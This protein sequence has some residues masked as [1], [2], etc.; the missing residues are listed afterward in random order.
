MFNGISG[1]MT[2]VW[3]IG[4]PC[5][6]SRMGMGLPRLLVPY[7]SVPVDLFLTIPDSGN[8]FNNGN[9]T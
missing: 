7:G 8:V 5:A 4:P 1:S 2:E 9:E 6:G 3:E